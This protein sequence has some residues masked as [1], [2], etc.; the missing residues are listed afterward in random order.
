MREAKR[1]LDLHVEGSEVLPVVRIAQ[2]FSAL[3]EDTVKALK[4]QLQENVIESLL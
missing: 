3:S 2:R 1:S 4:C